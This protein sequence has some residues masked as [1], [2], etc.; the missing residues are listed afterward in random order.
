MTIKTKGGYGQGVGNP[1]RSTLD[2]DKDGV[3]DLDANGDGKV[4]YIDYDGSITVNSN[5][6]QTAQDAKFTYNG[7]S[8]VRSSNTITD[9]ISGA[10]FTLNK[11]TTSTANLSIKQDTT[12]IPTLVDSFVSAFNTANS[13]IK[14]LTKYDS[15]TKTTGTLQGETAVSSI[16]SNMAQL[17]T[18]IEPTTGKS[19][20]D[21]GF[22]LD[23]SGTLSVDKTKLTT[24]LSSDPTTL[25]KVFRGTTQIT[26]GTY[27]GT[28]TASATATTVVGSGSIII[29]GISIASVTT[30]N[31]NTSE[32]NAQL[33]A[34]AINYSYAQ[35]RFLA[36][37]MPLLG[38]LL[39]QIIKL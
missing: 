3:D 26:K 5:T 36:L 29:N 2:T 22:S 20:M 17:I 10:T 13:K 1:I 21:Y 14:D 12:S 30:Q 28:N 24:A 39:K 8:M 15:S 37:A 7:I 27:T 4:N 31:T 18:K 38:K 32:Q 6:L 23:K 16:Y 35:D 34:A 33:F 19:L 25:E 11:V 9:I